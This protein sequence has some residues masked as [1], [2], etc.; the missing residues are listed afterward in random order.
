MN[1]ID[2]VEHNKTK[3]D[4][5]IEMAEKS[6]LIEI[7]YIFTQALNLGIIKRKDL[8]YQ[9]FG[10]LLGKTKDD[11]ISYLT[12]PVNAEQLE[13]IQAAVVKMQPKQTNVKV[14]DNKKSDAK[15]EDE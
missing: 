12:M 4:Y 6:N 1:V 13:K 11:S 2:L 10:Y 7:S 9:A 5:F 14:K 15:I 8:T 3:Q